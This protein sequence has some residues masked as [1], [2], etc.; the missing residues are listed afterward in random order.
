MSHESHMTQAMLVTFR[1]AFLKNPEQMVFCTLETFL[2]QETTSSLCLS[3][4]PSIC[5][6]TS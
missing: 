4:M 2:P 1:A 6:L 5:F 3:I